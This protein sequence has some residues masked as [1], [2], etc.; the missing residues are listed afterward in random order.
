MGVCDCSINLVSGWKWGVGPH[1]IKLTCPPTRRE[2][3]L[4]VLV[5]PD[6]DVRRVVDLRGEPKVSE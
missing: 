5:N 3:K 4:P 6:E 1:I 2:Y